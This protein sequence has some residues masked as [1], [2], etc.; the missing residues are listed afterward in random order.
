MYQRTRCQRAMGAA[1]LGHKR[2]LTKQMQGKGGDIGR[3][4]DE[5][6]E[7]CGREEK[8]GNG[9]EKQVTGEVSSLRTKPYGNEGTREIQHSVSVG[10]G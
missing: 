2:D 3:C 7:S 8:G 9:K 6:G 10:K 1:R 4:R 5:S